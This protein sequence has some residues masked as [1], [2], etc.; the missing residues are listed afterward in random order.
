MKDKNEKISVETLKE[1][2]DENVSTLL[3]QLKE[4]YFKQTKYLSIP[5]KIDFIIKVELKEV[6]IVKDYFHS[7]YIQTKKEVVKYADS[8]VY[9]GNVLYR[10]FLE[11]ELHRLNTLIENG[12]IHCSEQK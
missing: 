2:Y 6:E 10:K 12:K 4:D 1:G 8:V 3:K 11:K 7:T 9:G 5:S